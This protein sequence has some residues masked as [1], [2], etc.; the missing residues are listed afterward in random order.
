MDINWEIYKTMEALEIFKDPN[1][2]DWKGKQIN[3]R[4]KNK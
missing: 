1:F 3:Y 2:L 4:N